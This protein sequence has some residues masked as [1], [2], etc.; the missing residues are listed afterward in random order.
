MSNID[1]VTSNKD[2][3][4]ANDLFVQVMAMSQNWDAVDEIAARR[5]NEYAKDAIELYGKTNQDK[6]IELK[7]IIEEAEQIIPPDSLDIWKKR[8]EK[9]VL[10]LLPK[11]SRKRK[12]LLTIGGLFIVTSFIAPIFSTIWSF[13]TS[14][15]PKATQEKV[16]NGGRPQEPI[17]TQAEKKPPPKD[18]NANE[19][20]EESSETSQND[21]SRMGQTAAPRIGRSA[22]N[23]TDSQNISFKESAEELIALLESR[24]NTIDADMEGEIKRFEARGQNRH[25]LAHLR[26]TQGKRIRFK[27]LHQQHVKAIRAG[28]LTLAHVHLQSIKELLGEHRNL[29]LEDPIFPEY[30]TDAY[31]GEAPSNIRSETKHAQLISKVWNDPPAEAIPTLLKVIR[32]RDHDEQFISSTL[33][34]LSRVCPPQKK[35]VPVL[36]EL[37]N[38][39]AAH[40]SIRQ[41]VGKKLCIL[42]PKA[43]DAVSPLIEILEGEK[44]SGSDELFIEVLGCIGP[45]AKKALPILSKLQNSE[46]KSVSDGAKEAI[47]RIRSN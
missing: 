2:I 13:I 39:P 23:T 26:N 20:S 8:A 38:H 1:E 28:Q 9:V 25:V 24:A 14:S 41:S 32:D 18:V 31:P 33:E 36:V 17:Q 4:R 6:K 29:Y 22:K 7:R 30:T 40:Y 37:L 34:V 21:S 43:Q 27:E 45:R 5:I 3:A 12:I 10:R 19:A 15:K 16:T 46:W 11:S 47:R 35:Y 42:G 44:R